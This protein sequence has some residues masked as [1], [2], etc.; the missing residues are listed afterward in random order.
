MANIVKLMQMIPDLCTLQGAS[1]EEIHNAEQELE[2]KFAAD[3]RKYVATFGAVSF[4]SHELTGVCKSKRLSVV[5]V[6]IKERSRIDVPSDWYVLEQGNIDG[7]V[8]WQ[9]ANGKVY[10]TSPGSK[11]K[12]VCGS[13]SEYIEM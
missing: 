6:T 8:I 10:Q 7:V 1:E 2:L 4:D 5:D 3:Y 11:Q 12:K 13:L 9:D